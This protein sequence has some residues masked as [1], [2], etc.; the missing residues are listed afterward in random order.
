[1]NDLS[2][3][4]FTVATD[5]CPNPERWTSADS[6]S[7]EF[8]VLE[9]I[10]SLVRALQPEIVVETGSA[11]GYGSREIGKALKKNGHGRLYSLEYDPLRVNIARNRC[12]GLP[13]EIVQTDSLDWTPPGPIGFAFFDSLTNLR[14]PEFRAYQPWLLPG[15][16]IAFHD[17]APQHDLYDRWLL[18]LE[19]SGAIK[20]IRLHNPR[21]LALAEVL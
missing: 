13:V 8:E 9:L 19:A 18:P 21:G 1:V 11:F 2:E 5:F 3:A 6:D 20:M 16:T 7:T 14:V 12:Q 17:A 15:T 10:G 4:R